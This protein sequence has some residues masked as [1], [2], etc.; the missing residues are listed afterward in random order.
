M[1]RPS[2]IYLCVFLVAICGLVYELIC[3]AVASYLLG[4]SITQY[5]LIIGIFL[6]AMGVGSYLSKFVG[7]G[8]AKTLIQL[9]VLLGLVGGFAAQLLFFLFGVHGDIAAIL[10]GVTAFIGAIVGAEIPLLIR[11]LPKNKS[12]DQTI[13]QVFAWDYCGAF[14]ASVS[15]PFV[16]MPFFGLVRAG[17]AFGMFNIL[18]ALLLYLRLRKSHQLTRRLPAGIALA[19][20][21]LVAALFGGQKATTF[22]E[23]QLYPDSIVLKEVSPYQN[24]VVTRWQ[25]DTRLFLNGQLQFSS[26]DE[27]RYHESLILPALALHQE[28]HP[29]RPPN[30]LIL[31]GGDGLAARHI[32]KHTEVEKITIVDLDKTL[33]RLFREH[34]FLKQLNAASLTHPKVEVVNSDAFHYLRT[35]PFQRFDLIF[36][37]LPDPSTKSLPKLYS[38]AFYRMAF[39]RLTAK[40]SFVTQATSPFYARET[41]WCIESTLATASLGI[42]H[43]NWQVTPYHAHVPSFGDWGFVWI[44][45][46]FAVSQL[47]PSS[48]EFLSAEVFAGLFQFPPD[49]QRPDQIEVNTLGHPVVA[50]YHD[51]GW[52]Q[53]NQ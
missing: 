44:G 35:S 22:L 8:Y 9:Q 38:T 51:K 2:A 39:E 24:I 27:H 5:S 18:V 48:G 36:A 16:I 49:V 23:D 15:F 3:G 26:V 7:D 45:P 29:N 6:S 40:G 31:G 19:A 11:L 37:D 43:K 33:T 50:Q 42:H 28:L 41:F 13:A 14:V 17:I 47:Q 21:V 52:H 25:D 20:A 32:L 4:S 10:Y 46:P 1:L 12:L 53:Y 34:A 30:I